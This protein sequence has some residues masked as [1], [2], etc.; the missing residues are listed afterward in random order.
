M[1]H[2]V[3]IPAFKNN[4]I[5]AIHSSKGSEIAVVDP[6]DATPVLDYLKE[7]KLKLSAFF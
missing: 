4:Y 2:I 5:W 6:S 7:N 1:N 3:A